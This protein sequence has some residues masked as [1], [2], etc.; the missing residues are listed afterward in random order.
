MLTKIL[1]R[2]EE[3]SS[4][5]FCQDSTRRVVSSEDLGGPRK[6]QE[7]PG[8][9]R[10]SSYSVRQVAPALLASLALV[11][12]SV[13]VR[14]AGSRPGSLKAGFLGLAC[15]LALGLT[16]KLACRL[17]LARAWLGLKY[18]ATFHNII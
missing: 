6:S 18:F 14:L 7:V 10:R 16:F 17:G 2:F 1:I 15:K 9:P 4:K 12:Q 3:D 11:G 5:L 8:R 13:R